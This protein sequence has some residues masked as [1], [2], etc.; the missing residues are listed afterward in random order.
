MTSYQ[1]NNNS[2]V[3]LKKGSP[4]YSSNGTNIGL[5]L[6]SDNA[7]LPLLGLL[8]SDTLNGTNGSIQRAFDVALTIAEWDY[9]LETPTTTGLTAGSE[10]WLS[11]T[12]AGK[13]TP[14]KP[15]NSLNQIKV[16][17][18]ITATKLD[19]VF[20]NNNLF[21]DETNN[22]VD[23]LTDRVVNISTNTTGFEN[24]TDS[25]LLFDD[26][27]RTFTIQ[28]TD[29][30]YNIYKNGIKYTIDT[31]KTLVIPNTTGEYFIYFDDNQDLQYLEIF[32]VSLIRTKIYV[33]VLHYNSDQE[34]ILTDK[35]CDERH[36][37]SM[38]ADTH[39]Y[40][41]STIGAKWIEGLGLTGFTIDGDGSLDS[42]SQF[43]AESGSFAD[44]DIRHEVPSY[45]Q[46]SVFYRSGTEWRSKTADAF[47][48][49]FNGQEGYTGTR[50]CFNEN[51][52]E[53]YQLTEVTNDYYILL[54]G[55]AL[56]SKQVA[57]F[58]GVNEYA[59]LEEARAGANVELSN[60]NGLPF[61]E[62]I[63]I[64]SVIVKCSNSFTNTHKVATVST[65]LGLNYVDFRR[66]STLN[67][68]NAGSDHVHSQYLTEAQA[69][70]LYSVL[71]HSHTNISGNAA[72]AT[73][74][75]TPRTINGV[76]FDGTSNITITA[77]AGNHASTHG[78]GGADEITI[79]A[80]QVTTGTLTLARN[81]T[82]T[83]GG[84]LTSDDGVNVIERTITGIGSKRI[85]GIYPSV[86]GNTLYY[87]T[88]GD[89][90]IPV[91]EYWLYEDFTGGTTT[92][93]NN[94]LPV[95][96]GTGAGVTIATQPLVSDRRHGVMTLSTGTTATGRCSYHNGLTNFV[97]GNNGSFYIDVVCDIP[98]LSTATQEYSLEIGLGDNTGATANQTNGIYF[99]YDR[100]ISPNW[101]IVTSNGGTRT[102][103][104][105]SIAVKTTSWTY[106]RI[107][108]IPSTS[109]VE[110]YVDSVLAGS[111]STNIPT[112]STAVMGHLFKIRK[113]VGTTAALFHV[114]SVYQWHYRT[115]SLSYGA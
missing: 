23:N 31:A 33:A 34:N 30:S 106:L 6:A 62:F 4:V 69:N 27:T 107:V 59:T 95:P 109:T 78:N 22:R 28:P 81:T 21:G 41:H 112:I 75:Q 60:F 61:Q 72:T 49:I 98:T 11:D 63:K 74:L 89:Y 53:N 1:F 104:T 103:S 73:A 7:K 80:S 37:I 39:Y 17:Y 13:I 83:R 20:A 38:S 115:N 90:V 2:G 19:I 105:S 50:I 56:N 42:H 18:A 102:S 32:D 45:S 77:V 10:Y 36:G 91:R 71:S 24:L 114:D 87:M 88:L 85:L 66:S 70:T 96:S 58:L 29:E 47:P 93:Q 44:E 94:W 5:A 113:T 76:A 14:T 3:T 92:G 26:L 79:D 97:I 84:F 57:V 9:I 48:F 52:A 55:Y 35:P 25:E 67:I 46:L 101:I 111:I 86:G 8:T 99:R 43:T 65:D 12:I 68:I 82:L 54:H 15:S 40:A 108:V 16:G 51:V 100:T 110:F 64:G